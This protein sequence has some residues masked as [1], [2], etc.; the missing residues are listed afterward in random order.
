MSL[1]YPVIY[2]WRLEV[3]LILLKEIEGG[4][5]A[6]KAHPDVPPLIWLENGSIFEQQGENFKAVDPDRIILV[7]RKHD[8]DNEEVVSYHSVMEITEIPFPTNTGV[9]VTNEGLVRPTAIIVES[10]YVLR[11]LRQCYLKDNNP[12]GAFGQTFDVKVTPF[13]SVKSELFKN[14]S[15]LSD[16][17]DFAQCSHGMEDG[18][19]CEIEVFVDASGYYCTCSQHRT[20]SR[21]SSTIEGALVSWDVED[22]QLTGSC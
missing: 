7:G 6:P 2:Q 17:V 3:N 18:Q 20:V 10:D 8:T 13:W 9:A 1:V 19:P 21:H 22:I 16:C 15:R 4:I 5:E 11:S 12:V 14:Q